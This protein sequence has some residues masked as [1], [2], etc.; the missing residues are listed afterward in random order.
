MNH[1]ALYHESGLWID[2]NG[3]GKLDMNKSEEHFQDGAILSVEGKEYV[4]N[5]DYP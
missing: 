5:L 4:L 3:D 1:D 2:L